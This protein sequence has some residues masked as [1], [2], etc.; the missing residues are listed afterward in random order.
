MSKLLITGFNGFIGKHLIANLSKTEHS[1]T[2]SDM[3]SRFDI[4]ESTQ[5]E[6]IPN[7]DCVIHLAGKSFVPDSWNNPSE[8]IQA[9][10]QG[11]INALEYC[12]KNKALLVFLSSYLYGDPPV[13]PTP[14]ISPLVVTNPYAFSKSV[15]EDVCRFYAEKLNTR[16][17]VLRVFN[18][19]G[20][21][22]SDNFLIPTI[23]RQMKNNSTILL[24][25]TEP[26]RDYVYVK[27][28]VNA[29]SKS[30]NY[31]DEFG[32]FNIG[33]GRSYSVV[34]LVDTIMDIK[35]EYYNVKSLNERRKGEIMDTIADISQ[36]KIKLNWQPLWGIHEGLQETLLH[37]L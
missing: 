35:G 2:N 37:Y 23:L 9:N 8:F 4:T 6:S 7:V 17:V 13:I 18:V 19:Y 21:G 11:V 22:Q 14:E 31:T 12:R 29:I 30:I 26:K 27:D 25:D 34:E 24:K 28:V 5:W 1:I 16:V 36:A 10:F 32:I 15:S 3:F 20:P 33:S